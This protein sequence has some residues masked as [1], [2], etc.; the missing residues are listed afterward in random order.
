M[1]AIISEE[2]IRNLTDR[3]L[4]VYASILC[5]AH[6]GNGAVKLS[7][8]KKLAN[9]G[10]TQLLE[11]LRELENK[12]L[13]IRKKKGTYQ[14]VFELK[15]K[16]NVD[17]E[18]FNLREKKKIE[19]IINDFGLSKEQVEKIIDY[20]RKQ[21]HI[22]DK[23][24]YFGFLAKNFNKIFGNTIEPINA[25]EIESKADFWNFQ[26]YLSQRKIPFKVEKKGSIWIFEGFNVGKFYQD[27]LKQKRGVKNDL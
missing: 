16:F 4:K 13:L 26:I 17:L 27:Y 18:G 15:L 3:E 7:E 2:I 1:F 20:I 24:R 5:L 11:I 23:S 25:V 8:I 21:K 9:K 10:Y 6:K 19:K 22:K 12:K 14:I